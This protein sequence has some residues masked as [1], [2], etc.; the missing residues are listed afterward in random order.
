MTD[1]TNM[2]DSYERASAMAWALIRLAPEPVP[3]LWQEMSARAL[4]ALFYAASPEDTGRG[5]NWVYQTLLNADERSLSAAA[6]AAGADAEM[7]RRLRLV[8]DLDPGQRQ[9]LIIAM[10]RAVDPW[11]QPAHAKVS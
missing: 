2:I 1:P 9:T 11:L 8:D 6:S 5:M 3:A 10:R 7:I 4:A